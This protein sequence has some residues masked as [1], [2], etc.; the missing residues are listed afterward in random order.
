MRK[1]LKKLYEGNADIRDYEVARCISKKESVEIY[2]E[3]DKMTL[4]P[5]DLESKKI[6]TSGIIDS[7]F[8]GKSYRLISYAWNPDTVEL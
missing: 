5:E 1:D 8:G 7:K 6:K 3:G 4:S 2:F